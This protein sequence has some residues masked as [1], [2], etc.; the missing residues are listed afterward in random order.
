MLKCRWVWNNTWTVA[1]VLRKCNESITMDGHWLFQ[2]VILVTPFFSP[3]ALPS[4]RPIRSRKR[5]SGVPYRDWCSQRF[6][7]IWGSASRTSESS[8]TSSLSA[9]L[10]HGR[11][12]HRPA[13]EE[14][15][16][17]TTTAVHT[18]C[19]AGHLRHVL[20]MFSKKWLSFIVIDRP[21]L[22]DRLSSSQLKWDRL[23]RLLEIHLLHVL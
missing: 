23:E 3:A 4:D 2:L 6:V 19:L 16:K 18:S 13:K 10:F 11:Y 15:I 21:T 1:N 14:T 8:P 12:M 22:R 20:R 17:T 5:P 9:R 7:S